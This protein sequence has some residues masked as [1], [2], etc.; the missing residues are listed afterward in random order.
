MLKTKYK[1]N[2]TMKIFFIIPV[3]LLF[4]SGL[5]GQ[6]IY[7]NGGKIVV[8][9]G[10]TLFINGS[11]GNFRNETNVANGSIDLTGTLKI[12]GNLI[13][14]VASADIFT[15][16]A[17]GS[18]VSLSGSTMQT[19]GGSTTAGFTFANLTIDNI[20]GV[21]IEQ[22][23]LV[24]GNM[25]FIN[26]I[27]DIGN[28]NFMFGPLSSVSGTPSSA[29]MIIATG[30]GQVRKEWTAT[31][32]FTFPVGDNIVIAE[33]SPVTLNFTSGTFAPGA[34]VGLNLVNARYDDPSI[35]GSY[36]NRYWNITQTGITGFTSDA[37]FQ[38]ETADIVGT[39][40]N[41]YSF[42]VNPTPVTPFSP[43]NTVL[44]NLT[45]TGLTSF[46]TF[47][48][49]LG[50]K[51][52]SLKLYLEGYYRGSG[53][54]AQAK[55]TSGNQFPGTTVDQLTIEL[56]DPASYS[57][58]V[59]SVP[60]IDLNNSGMASVNIPLTYS[61]TYYVTVKQ[62]NN[63]NIVTASPLLFSTQI[64]SY[65]FSTATTQAFGSKLKNLEPGVFGMYSGD[66][67]QDGIIDLGDLIPS[68]NKAA[69]AGSGFIP[70]DV[71]GDG[72][73]DLSD[74]IIIGNNAAAAVTAITP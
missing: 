74:L 18:E 19:V 10:I 68:G 25:A 29:T 56:H 35:T 63:I 31:G 2:G 42:R 34:F 73:V 64:V 71:N 24:N 7:N 37:D 9:S 55:G 8:G 43:S 52:L 41:I 58:I 22:N 48:G 17:I 12:Q 49:G 23:A 15:T 72:L 69:L 66:V 6:G 5:F 62:R 4:S 54:M 28:N 57:T 47:T 36:L 39:E 70:E 11:N 60:N 40:S 26:G 13:N 27:S 45:A 38:Y 44:H 32:S 21:L 46:G 33:Y 1:S 14:N 20:S 65:D 30:T 3:A 51:V 50:L 16:S 59:Y 61:G 67:N 53:V